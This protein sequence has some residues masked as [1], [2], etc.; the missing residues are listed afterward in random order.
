MVQE[1]KQQLIYFVQKQRITLRLYGVGGHRH[2]PEIVQQLSEFAGEKVSLTFIP[3]LLPTIRGIFS[4]IYV[5]LT[6]KGMEQDFQK[7]YEQRYANEP[8]LM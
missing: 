8:L 5:Q 1:E 3:H 6:E 7:L 2:S 4:T